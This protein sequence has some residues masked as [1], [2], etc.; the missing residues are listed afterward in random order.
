M[1]WLTLLIILDPEVCSMWHYIQIVEK[2][3]PQ[4]AWVSGTMPLKTSY[5]VLY[6]FSNFFA[7]TFYPVSW[8]VSQPFYS[9]KLSKVAATYNDHIQSKDRQNFFAHLG[10]HSVRMFSIYGGLMGNGDVWGFI[11][12]PRIWNPYLGLMGIM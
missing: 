2:C 10:N 7:Q 8:T 5:I 11:F 9:T 1:K 6:T 3:T 12:H 4:N